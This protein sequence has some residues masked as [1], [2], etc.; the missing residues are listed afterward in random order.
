MFVQNDLIVLWNIFTCTFYYKQD[1]K[2]TENKFYAKSNLLLIPG[3]TSFIY[4]LRAHIFFHACG[5][6]PYPRG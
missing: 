2:I 1:K 4:D 6:A 5:H 3:S